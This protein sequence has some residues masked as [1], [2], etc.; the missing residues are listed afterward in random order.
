MACD[1]HG[2][3]RERVESRRGGDVGVGEASAA[4]TADFV[5][6]QMVAAVATGQAT[7]EEAAAEAERRAKRYYRS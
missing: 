7:P 5:V 2:G 4:V 3:R 6:V 1:P